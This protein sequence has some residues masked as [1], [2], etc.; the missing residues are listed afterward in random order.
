MSLRKVLQHAKHL[1]AVLPVEVG[2]LE[3]EGVQERALRSALPGLLLRQ[4]KKAPPMS[5]AAMVLLHQFPRLEAPASRRGHEKRAAL[6]AEPAKTELTVKS[7]SSGLCV[8]AMRYSS[9]MGPLILHTLRL[10]GGPGGP[11]E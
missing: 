9:A 8:D 1:V 10:S 7:A 5:L 2:S 4:G 3:T 6:G 11:R